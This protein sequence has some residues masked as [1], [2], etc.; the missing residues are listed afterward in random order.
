MAYSQHYKRDSGL[1]AETGATEVQNRKSRRAQ[2]E[3]TRS[4]ALTL[5]PSD[6]ERKARISWLKELSINPQSP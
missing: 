2:R 3:G 5:K 6:E 4:P 1:L